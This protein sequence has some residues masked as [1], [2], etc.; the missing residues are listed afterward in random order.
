MAAILGAGAVLLSAIDKPAWSTFLIAA[1]FTLFL[2]IILRKI[3][4]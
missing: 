4:L 1:I 2:S 3:K